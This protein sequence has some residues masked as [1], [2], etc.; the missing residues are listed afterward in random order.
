MQ[1]CVEVPTYMAPP[2]PGAPSCDPRSEPRASPRSA[3]DGPSA[4]RRGAKAAMEVTTYYI[5]QHDADI[6]L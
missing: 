4:P 6:T 3:H 5:L 2:A 1:I